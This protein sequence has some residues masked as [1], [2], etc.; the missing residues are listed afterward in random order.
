M[1]G[2]TGWI[3][4]V[5]AALALL[6]V[7]FL[8][9]YLTP[10]LR[11]PGDSSP[12]AGFARDMS[13]HHG[14]AVAM[15]MLEVQNGIDPAV[16]QLAE[17]IATTQQAQIGMMT[18]WLQDWKLLP[19]GSRRPMAWMPD[20]NSELVNGLMPGMATVDQLNQLSAARGKASDVLF[21]QLMLRHH[22]GGIHMVEGILEETHNSQVR[23]LA[24]TMLSGQQGEV[25]VLQGELK[26][27]GAQPLS[28]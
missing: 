13:T 23:T 27:L 7:G 17:D 6:V 5:V 18:V 10:S 16:R 20:A 4:G 11:A 28:S 24:E 21:C 25:T 26:T 14:Q 8:G 9:G 15:A 2:R 12:E 1:S 22:I 3:V 19:T